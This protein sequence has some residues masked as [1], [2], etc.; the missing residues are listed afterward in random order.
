MYLHG[1]AILAMIF[2]KVCNRR[3]NDNRTVLLTDGKS[4][5]CTLTPAGGV[6]N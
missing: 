3:Y 2:L 1:S 4:D 6:E 5:M